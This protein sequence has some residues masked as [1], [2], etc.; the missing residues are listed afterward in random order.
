[1]SPVR[2]QWDPERS[3]TLQPLPW[4]SI[5]IGLSGEAVALYVHDWIVDLA[6]V[7]AAAH[8]L[9]DLERVC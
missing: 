7:T 3:I 9:H 8:K 6:D 2:I 4:R 1:M 5:Q